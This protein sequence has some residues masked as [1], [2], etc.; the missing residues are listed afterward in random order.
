VLALALGFLATLAWGLGRV[1]RRTP[2]QRPAPRR[3]PRLRP[4]STP[5]G[6]R[7]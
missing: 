6:I 4:I 2:D 1:A 7:P 3:L 5:I